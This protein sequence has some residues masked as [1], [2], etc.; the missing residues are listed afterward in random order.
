MASSI[1][2]NSIIGSIVNGRFKVVKPIGD[3]AQ[4]DVFK[5]NDLKDDNRM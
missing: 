4:G 2:N 1:N 5:V 3:G